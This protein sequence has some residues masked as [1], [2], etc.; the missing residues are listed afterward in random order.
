MDIGDLQHEAFE[1][2][3]EHNGHKID[4]AFRSDVTGKT[5]LTL[6]ALRTQI[7]PEPMWAEL[8]RLILAWDLTTKGEPLPI[9]DASWL[10]L[11]G[12]L[13]GSFIAAI[14]LAVSDPN[15]RRPL[16]DG[17]SQVA[18]SEPTASPSSTPLSATRDGH[19]P[20]SG[21]SLVSP[22]NPNSG[23]AGAL[24]YGS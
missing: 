12:E 17:W 9:E 5:I 21:L 15:K 18:A 8:N 7:D 20:P 23:P 22:M 14:M 10:T 11:P 13:A 1:T 24:G 2:T 6:K 19:T 16:R 3:A 4:F